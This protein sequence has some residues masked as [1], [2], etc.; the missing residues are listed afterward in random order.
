MSVLEKS[1]VTIDLDV[2]LCLSFPGNAQPFVLRTNVAD[3]RRYS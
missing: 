2:H 1:G 3:E